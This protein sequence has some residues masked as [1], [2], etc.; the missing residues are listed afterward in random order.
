MSFNLFS[1]TLNLALACLQGRTKC[2]DYLCSRKEKKKKQEPAGMARRTV[3]AVIPAHTRT[4]CKASNTGAAPRWSRCID[5]FPAVQP[6]AASIYAVLQ[7]YYLISAL[8]FF[9]STLDP[10][11]TRHQFTSVS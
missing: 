1:A 5:P 11:Q 8:F 7:L 4:A 2:A 3:R 9:H 6:I 10:A